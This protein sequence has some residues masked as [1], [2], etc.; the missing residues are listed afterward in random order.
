[1]EEL[2]RRT[3]SRLHDAYAAGHVR[4]G[5]LEQRI[6]ATL[7]AREPADLDTVTW[8]LPGRR[9]EPCHRVVFM[10]GPSLDIDEEDPRT[11]IVGRS[12]ACDVR[13][14]EATVSR[15]HAVMSSRGGACTIRDLGSS[16]GLFVNGVRVA[17]AELRPGDV[18]G[19]AGAIVA[20]VR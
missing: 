1:M 8:D 19:F 12:R 15:R 4:V 3:L 17:T 11:W 9:S 18:V 7:A 14:R 2:R 10:D 5:T 20:E 16:N 6:E 13:V